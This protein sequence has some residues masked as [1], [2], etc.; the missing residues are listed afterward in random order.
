MLS[1]IMKAHIP[2]DINSMRV[3]N[4]IEH[5]EKLELKKI[6]YIESGHGWKS[7]DGCP[8]CG[9]AE[10]DPEFEVH[11][12]SLVKCTGC[13]V[14]YHTKIPADLNDIYQ[15]D[16]HNPHS[17]GRSD[18]HFNYRKERFGTE[19]VRLLERFCGDLSEKT[20]LDVGCGIGDFLAA[21]KD[22]C[23]RCI[24]SEFSL[25]LREFAKKKTGL[26]IYSA[27]LET[28]PEQDINIITAIDVLEHIPAPTG[29]L[30]AASNLLKPGGHIM[31]YTPNFDSFSIKVMGPY[32][33]ILN[34]TEH[35]ILFNHAS[36]K[37]LGEL[38]GLEVIHTET[39]GLDINSIISFQSYIGEKEVKFLLQWKEELQ[40]MIDASEC[41]D[42]LRVIY[43][44]V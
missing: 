25:D 19:R 32:S 4:F 29:F 11:G 40:A 17:K 22:A 43:K 6:G 18:E 12:N 23:K 2:V 13:Q 20:L 30:K 1:K 42:Y 33:N 7:V 28:F 41:A 21:A 27:P 8:V 5:Q 16:D 34:G 9:T 24:G 10:N 39:R 3:K 44:K 31:L 26:E 35:V 36:L 38:A 15:A 37:K 14:R